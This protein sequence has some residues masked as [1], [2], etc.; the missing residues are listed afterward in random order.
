VRVLVTDGQGF[1]RLSVADQGVG[2]SAEQVAHV[3]DRFYRVDASNT[4]VKGVG[5]GMSI[6]RHIVQAHGGDVHIDSQLGVG[7][8]VHVDLPVR[9]PR[10]PSA[11]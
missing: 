6:V 8:T 5:L 10:Q 7:T 4:A 11:V 9:Q 3:F 2:M 1:C